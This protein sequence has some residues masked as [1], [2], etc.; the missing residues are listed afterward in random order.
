ML[1][2]SR[3]RLQSKILLH[4]H[5][6]I[7]TTNRLVEFKEKWKKSIR[8]WSLIL[9]HR[10]Q[11]FFNLFIIHCSQQIIIIY[12]KESNK[13]WNKRLYFTT[14]S[15]IAILDLKNYNNSDLIVAA[16]SKIFS[17][18]SSIKWIL[19]SFLLKI[20]ARWK[21]FVL[22]SPSFNPIYPRIPSPKN[23]LWS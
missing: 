23:L 20:V 5:T 13:W 19:F 1:S 15:S 9:S 22:W 21:D 10:S 3:H 4:Y 17:L 16:C 11:S 2:R 18:L 14:S 8:A 7:L 6:N 12:I